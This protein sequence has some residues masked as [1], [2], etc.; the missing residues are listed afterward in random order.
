MGIA[1]I[2]NEDRL[3]FLGKLFYIYISGENDM[4]ASLSTPSP[5]AN[6]EGATLVVSKAVVRAGGILGLSNALMARVLGI[7]ASTSSR[8]HS[9]H[10]VLVLD[11]KPFE[12]ALLLIRLF[13]G[14]DAMLGGE[15]AAIRSWMQAPNHALGAAPLDMIT[16]VTG[17][18]EAVTYVDS[19]RARI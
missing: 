9:G 8:L 17:L 12:L 11:S 10:H 5:T 19:S 4:R 6:R 18:V 1:K 7:S 15:E 3:E 2:P 13:R 16:S 14:L